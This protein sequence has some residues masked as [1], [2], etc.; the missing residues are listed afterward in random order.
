VGTPASKNIWKSSEGPHTRASRKS[1]EYT[2]TRVR[3]FE[4][5]TSSLARI[6]LTISPTQYIWLSRGCYPLI[7]IRRRPFSN[8]TRD[9]SPP[10]LGWCYQ[11][12][13]KGH[14][15]SLGSCEHQS[16][17]LS[18]L[19]SEPS[20]YAKTPK[21]IPFA[22]F[23]ES[24]S[25]FN[26]VW[27]SNIVLR[28]DQPDNQVGLDFILLAI[29]RPHWRTRCWFLRRHG[30]CCLHGRRHPWTNYKAANHYMRNE[31]AS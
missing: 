22:Y 9:K 24:L 6:F 30:H 3:G 2:R 13:Q 10:S 11:P 16:V 31:Y 8:T 29:D 18:G 4:L 23:T 26:F 1:R 21:K 19:N 7:V 25:R 15:F 12:W 28:H 5:V 17:K 14:L 20:N 27:D